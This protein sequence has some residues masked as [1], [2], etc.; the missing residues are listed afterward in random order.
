MKERSGLNG[1]WNKTF[2]FRSR[3]GDSAR[4]SN[5]CDTFQRE[6]GVLELRICFQ[7]SSEL[8]FRVP[9]MRDKIS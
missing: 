3:V 7:S 6:E 1:V 5:K 4:F 9:R 2:E 8:I